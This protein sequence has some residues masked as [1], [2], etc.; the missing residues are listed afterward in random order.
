VN[1]L[2]P[3]IRGDL[4]A[5][6]QDHEVVLDFEPD[7]AAPRR[8]I[9]LDEAGI[10]ARYYNNIGVENIAAGN[11]AV[12]YA[13]FKAAVRAEPEYVSP[14]GNL[15]VLYRRAGHEAEAEKFLRYAISLDGNTDVAMHEL[16]RF[17]KDHGRVAEAA[18]VEHKLEAHQQKDPYHWIGL[19]LLDMEKK[20]FSR[21]VDKLERANEIAPTFVEVHRYLA[22]AYA[23]VGNP[24]KAR[25][26]LDVL[27]HVGG[28]FDK[29]AFLRRK[30]DKLDRMET[31]P[32]QQ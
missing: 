21:A 5:E 30:L 31:T 29:V 8:G 17:L 1:V 3:H 26:E 7:F 25:E 22:V 15:A 18:E 19:A 4:M 32:Q 10:A 6:S 16:H 20:D 24:Q 14:Y 28:S 23:R 12:A 11:Y 13:Y 27:A 9:P 2:F